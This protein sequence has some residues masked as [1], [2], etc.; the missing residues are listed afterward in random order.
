M[1]IKVGIGY[2]I[3]RF[4]PKRKLIL[5]GV[6]I[7]YAKGLLGHSDADIVLHAICDALLGALGEGD[8]GQLFPNTDKKYKNIS[9]L[10]L[11]KGVSGLL[12]KKSFCVGN[13][14]VMVILESPKIMPYSEQMK[15]NIV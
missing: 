15:K 7:S 13:I 2:D 9:S 12:R 5:G 10:V 11:L 6:N 8:V 4:A 14:D 1:N 3:H